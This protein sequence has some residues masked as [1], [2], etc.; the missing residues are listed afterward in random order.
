MEQA[1]N[2]LLAN[3]QDETLREIIKGIHHS[4][5]ND[6]DAKGRPYG[7]FG[8]PDPRYVIHP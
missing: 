8:E 4:S 2:E 6:R 5:P 3:T 7:R 1:I